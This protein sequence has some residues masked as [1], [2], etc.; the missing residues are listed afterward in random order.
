MMWLKLNNLV[1][2]LAA[3]SCRARYPKFEDQATQQYTPQIR[4]SYQ[5]CYLHQVMHG[6]GYPE[7]G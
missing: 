7:K 2:Q 6:T 3:V 4:T 5:L 1:G